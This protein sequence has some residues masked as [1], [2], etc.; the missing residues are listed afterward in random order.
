MLN[1]RLDTESPRYSF[2]LDAVLVSL[3]MALMWPRLAYLAGLNFGRWLR[4]EWRDALF[5]CS[6]MLVPLVFWL[7]PL[8][9]SFRNRRARGLPGF[10]PA[11]WPSALIVLNV[12]TLLV[13]VLYILT[14]LVLNKP[15]GTSQYFVMP[16]VMLLLVLSVIDLDRVVARAESGEAV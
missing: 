10:H 2:A 12:A 3:S 9:V 1:D 6:M 7:A 16:V 11:L 13:N 8:L 5:W 14:C 15:T 4:S